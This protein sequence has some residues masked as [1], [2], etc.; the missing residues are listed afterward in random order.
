[1][2]N[3]FLSA[4]YFKPLNKI[5]VKPLNKIYKW[6]KIKYC[7]RPAYTDKT[8]ADVI[9]GGIDPNGKVLIFSL[10]KVITI[11]LIAEVLLSGKERLCIRY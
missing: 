8:L 6:V 10:S 1:M 11:P 7:E 5:Y 9:R 4:I 2:L 3:G